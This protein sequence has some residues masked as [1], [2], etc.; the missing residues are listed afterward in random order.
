MTLHFTICNNLAWE[1]TKHGPGAEAEDSLDQG[2]I[3]D[4]EAIIWSQTAN[5][6]KV[7][8]VLFSHL[9]IMLFVL[10]VANETISLFYTFIL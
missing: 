6:K 7:V 3:V 10:Q 5:S 2:V 9:L 4:C 1:S 8:I